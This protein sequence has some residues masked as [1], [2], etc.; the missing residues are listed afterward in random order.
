[1]SSNLFVLIH[2][3]VFIFGYATRKGIFESELDWLNLTMG[4]E[5]EREVLRLGGRVNVLSVDI[6]ELLYFDAYFI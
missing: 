3:A 6:F 2:E 1:M 4:L 5:V